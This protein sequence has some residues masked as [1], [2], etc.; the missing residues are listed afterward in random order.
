MAVVN[1]RDAVTEASLTVGQRA[2]ACC[3]GLAARYGTDDQHAV[4]RTA[5]NRL[6][7]QSVCPIQSSFTSPVPS[8]SPHSN[9]FS[10]SLSS[11]LMSSPCRCETS[12][13][14]LQAEVNKKIP[15]LNSRQTPKYIAISKQATRL[16][17]VCTCVHACKLLFLPPIDA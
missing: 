12:R 9:L 15:G 8:I 16:R 11:H 10:S 1:V 6:I 17:E 4:E 3:V 5:P 14:Q 7:L 2:V 13:R